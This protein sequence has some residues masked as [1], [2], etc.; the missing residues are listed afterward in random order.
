MYHR[1]NFDLIGI[2]SGPARRRAAMQA[3][4]LGKKKELSPSSVEKPVE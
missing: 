4:K 1:N 2:G 3:A